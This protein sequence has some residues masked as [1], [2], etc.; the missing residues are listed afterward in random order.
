MCALFYFRIQQH[1]SCCFC[2]CCCSCCC[3]V[4]I[5]MVRRIFWTEIFCAMVLFCELIICLWVDKDALDLPGACTRISNE[6][7]GNIIFKRLFTLKNETICNCIYR[8]DRT[9]NYNIL[10]QNTF[11]GF[12]GRQ[13]RTKEREREICAFFFWSKF[14]SNIYNHHAVDSEH[15]TMFTTLRKWISA[16]CSHNNNKKTKDVLTKWNKRREREVKWMYRE[17]ENANEIK[18]AC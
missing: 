17:K 5:E 11:N 9:L 1:F 10:K 12:D 14:L 15:S 7:I 13:R 18:L 6:T 16:W 4:Q 8:F 3:A 2:C